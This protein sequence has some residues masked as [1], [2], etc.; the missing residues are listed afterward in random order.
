[1]KVV[2]QR[3]AVP[4][5]TGTQVIETLAVTED[6]SMPNAASFKADS[7]DFVARRKI[8]YEHKRECDF[9]CHL[10]SVI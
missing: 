7:G 10:R 3:S 5:E 9:T 1:M 2:P 4:S 8:G 6:S